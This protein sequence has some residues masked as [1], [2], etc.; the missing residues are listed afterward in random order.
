VCDFGLT[1]ESPMVHTGA[2][3]DFLATGTVNRPDLQAIAPLVNTAFTG[4]Q[5]D[6][7]AAFRRQFPNGLGQP[8]GTIADANGAYFMHTPPDVPGFVRCHPPEDDN[9]VLTRFV[10]ARRPGERLAGQD[11]T[12][13]TTVISRVVT[14]AIQ[15]GLDPVPIQDALLASLAPLKILL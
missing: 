2:L 7:A 15:A 11:V 9:L 6:L 10:R 1:M 5:T 3:A 8:V 4:R 13:A 14:Q 12:P